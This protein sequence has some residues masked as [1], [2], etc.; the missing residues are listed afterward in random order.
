MD[1]SNV[2]LVVTDMD[3]TLLNSKGEVSTLFFDLFKELRE[4]NI[5]FVA[6]SGRQYNSITNKLEK[7]VNDIT[8]IAEN[9]GIAKQG[10]D[11][12][13]VTNMPNESIHELITLLRKLEDVYVVLCGK[14]SSYI[15]TENEKFI[16]LF[17][18][19]Y[20]AYKVVDDLTK[21]TNDD[22]VKIAVY[23]FDSSEDHIYPAVQH[24]EDTLQVK[25]SGK[26]WLDLSHPNANKGYALKLLQ[27]KLGVTKEETMVFGDYN[28]DLE[29]LDLAHFSYAMEN[30]H[31]NVIKAANYKTK[32]NDEN[33][34]EFILDQL[35]K[36]K[37][38]LS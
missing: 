11:E 25:V 30:A 20:A 2:K 8:I 7:I 27:T 23:H 38:K 22:F 14:K 18:E 16:T 5:H 33:G 28:N 35:I 17:N 13:L 24:Y 3:G 12:L 32:S 19:Y 37:K 4:H 21:V 9:G 15:E 36:A 6:A 34:V 1:L 31:P 29:M 26:N 10:T